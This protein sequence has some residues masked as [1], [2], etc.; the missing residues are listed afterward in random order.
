LL[1]GEDGNLHALVADLAD[2]SLLSLAGA[3]PSAG[4]QRFRFVLPRLYT[5]APD[6][7]GRPRPPTPRNQ[8]HT[9]DSTKKAGNARCQRREAAPAAYAQP[10]FI[11]LSMRR[12]G[13]LPGGLELPGRI[14]W[15]WEVFQN[16]GERHELK[17][18]IRRLQRK[19][20]PIIRS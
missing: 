11:G 1:L 5:M 20:K 9:T 4:Q 17:R 8:G 10:G 18:T 6:V 16:T 7:I 3:Q 19:Y 14:F 12:K 15:A 13:D 2:V